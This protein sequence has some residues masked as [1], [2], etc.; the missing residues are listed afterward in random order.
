MRNSIIKVFTFIVLLVMVSSCSDDV[1]D[2]NEDKRDLTNIQLDYD[3][4]YGEISR[5]EYPVHLGLT[6]EIFFERLGRQKGDFDSYELKKYSFTG[7]ALVEH[8]V[9][10]GE[11]IQVWHEYT[12]EPVVVIEG[13]LVSGETFQ[14]KAMIIH[15]SNGLVY[16]THFSHW[17]PMTFD[18][19]FWNWVDGDVWPS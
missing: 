16:D 7:I 8:I 17:R 3:P 13:I 6:E 18:D 2:N 15:C 11:M 19:V 14:P 12:D 10:N 1:F 4:N 9:P 5:E